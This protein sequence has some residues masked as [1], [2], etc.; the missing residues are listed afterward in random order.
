MESIL[1]LNKS[2]KVLKALVMCPSTVFKEIFI[3]IGFVR[4]NLNV[5][6]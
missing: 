6:A 3:Y 5:T 4:V 1:P 2:F